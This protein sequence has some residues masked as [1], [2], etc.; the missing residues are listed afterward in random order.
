MYLYTTVNPTRNLRSHSLSEYF[1]TNCSLLSS[2][3]KSYECLSF[4]LGGKFRARIGVRKGGQSDREKEYVDLRN[5][6][7]HE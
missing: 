2:F 6:Q 1:H 5:V 7:E 4:Y 3:N